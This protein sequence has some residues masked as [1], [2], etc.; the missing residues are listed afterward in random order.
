MISKLSY[1]DKFSSG[2]DLWCFFFEPERDLFKAINWRAQFGI[3]KIKEQ[4]QLTQPLLIESSSFFPNKYLLCLPETFLAQKS[5][6]IW[7]QLKRPSVRLFLPLKS[8]KNFLD[9]WLSASSSSDKISYYSETT[10][11]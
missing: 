8:Q 1:Y 6:E 2:A 9:F 5:Y 7:V 10:G 3:Q 11:L 4:V